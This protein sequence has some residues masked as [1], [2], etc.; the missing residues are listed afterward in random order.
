MRAGNA[1]PLH[2]AE[3]KMS[4]GTQDTRCC[5]PTGKKD[6]SLANMT[7]KGRVVRASTAQ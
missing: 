1:S 5:G 3:H 7:K 2:S 4:Q 6:G